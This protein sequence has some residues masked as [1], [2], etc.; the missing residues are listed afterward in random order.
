M[1]LPFSRA[2]ATLSHQSYS[3]LFHTTVTS[4]VCLISGTRPFPSI[5]DETKEVKAKFKQ[6]QKGDQRLSFNLYGMGYLFRHDNRPFLDSTLA[7]CQK[8]GVFR[9]GCRTLSRSCLHQKAGSNLPDHRKKLKSPPT[10]DEAD[11][12]AKLKETRIKLNVSQKELGDVLGVSQSTVTDFESHNMSKDNWT[13]WRKV[14]DGWLQNPTASMKTREVAAKTKCTAT[15][16]S[17]HYLN[18]L[19]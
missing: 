19:L 6:P 11:F 16:R 18:Y 15:T 1:S 3:A 8:L 4:P 7:I 14:V 13:K 9:N 5:Y 10:K 12:V 2:L 17:G